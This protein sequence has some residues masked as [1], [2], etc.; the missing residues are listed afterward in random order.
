MNRGILFAIPGALACCALAQAC[1][2]PADPG[3]LH[4][5]DSLITFTEA[6]LL[7]LGELDTVRY[8]EAEAFHARHAATLD[9]LLRD[10][11]DSVHAELVVNTALVMRHT[12][13]MADDHRRVAVDLTASGQRLRALRADLE[14]RAMPAADA[15]G[16]VAHERIIAVDLD[17]AMHRLLDNYR[18]LQGVAAAFP[19]TDS[20]LTHFAVRP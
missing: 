6:A 14:Q 15:P 9:S 4:T 17:T 12:P 16:A 18:T 2:P 5:V 20:L 3:Q 19:R 13:R 7:T 11:L 1:R 8:A 10:T